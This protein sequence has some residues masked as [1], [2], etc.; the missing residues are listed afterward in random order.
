[1]FDFTRT[2]A[3]IVTGD[4]FIPHV[5]LTRN[6]SGHLLLNTGGPGGYYF[7]TAGLL[8]AFPTIMNET[9]FQRYLQEHGKIIISASRIYIPRPDK[10]QRKLEQL[11]A[12]KRWWLGPVHNCEGLVEEIVMAGGGPR[13]H[14]GWWSFPIDSTNQCMPW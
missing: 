2:Y 14:T 9:Q 13:L 7:M 10:S 12:A 1:M 5:D 11:L 3:V 4:D 8:F 6:K